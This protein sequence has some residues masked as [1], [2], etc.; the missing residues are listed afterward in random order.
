MVLATTLYTVVVITMVMNVYQVL[1][2]SKQLKA[3]GQTPLTGRNVSTVLVAGLA[4]AITVFIAI[5]AI[6]LLPMEPNILFTALAFFVI[7]AIRNASSYLSAWSMWS[8]F[9][10]RD[11]RKAEKQRKQMEQEQ[12]QGEA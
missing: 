4:E 12:E 10:N 9:L 1:T 3:Q 6:S 2:E 7:Y 5:Y 11:K 8:I